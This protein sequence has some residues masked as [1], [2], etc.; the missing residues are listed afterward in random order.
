MP[1]CQLASVF[2]VSPPGKH[3]S[4][5]IFV[6][7]NTYHGGTRIAVTPGPGIE[8]GPHLWEASALSIAPPLLPKSQVGETNSVRI[9]GF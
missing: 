9:K 6:R 7:G 1:S 4:L 3:I 8:P 2:C 5:V